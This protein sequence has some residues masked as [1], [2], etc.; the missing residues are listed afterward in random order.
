MNFRSTMT[1]SCFLPSSMA[2]FAS[3]GKS[4]ILIERPGLLPASFSGSSH[5]VRTHGWAASRW[6]KFRPGDSKRWA[7]ARRSSSDRFFGPLTRTDAHGFIDRADEDLAVTDAARLGALFDRVDDLMN[8]LIGDDDL[9]LDL[10]HEVHDV[11][12]AA[13]HFLLA[14]GTAEAF[15]LGHGH[16]LDTDFGQGIL[17]LVQL[18]RLDNRLDLLHLALHLFLG[19]IARRE[20][21]PP[22]AGAPLRS[23]SPAG[24]QARI[25]R[26][27]V[28]VSELFPNRVSAP[29]W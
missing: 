13:V 26:T 18:E 19:G 23:L 1:A 14:A 12:R 2:S 25:G 27:G 21:S 5:P 8:H 6:A 7:N 17:D 4:F 9:E 16:A 20:A 28:R 11:G 29:F 15:D 10:G 24:E 3:M 22:A